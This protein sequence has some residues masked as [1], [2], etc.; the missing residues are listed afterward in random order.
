MSLPTTAEVFVRAAS[1][2]ARV[3]FLLE[4]SDATADDMTKPAQ[5]ADACAV[6][7]PSGSA[8]DVPAPQMGEPGRPVEITYW[9]AA[10]QAMVD[11]RGDSIEVL[12]PN[13][14]VDHYPFQAA[15]LGKDA[16]AAGQLAA[17]YAPAR[18]L[19][20]A[21][22]GPR[23]RAV[24]DLRAEGPGTLSPAGG[25]ISEGRGRRTEGGWAVVLSRPLPT[26]FRAGR[27]QVAVA[28][29]QGAEREAGSRKMR[30]GWIPLAIEE[31]R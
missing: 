31:G 19:G 17:L 8:A 12:Y 24:E 14:A 29:W 2:G 11:G 28:I 3:A 4:W 5:F 30:S 23:T 16:A 20:Q 21:M 1:D 6:Q 15:P 22:G 18:S 13:A 10:W 26:A 27:S 7:L 9:R 25:A